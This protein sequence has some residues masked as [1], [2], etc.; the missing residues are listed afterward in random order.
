MTYHENDPEVDSNEDDLIVLWW[1]E[2]LWPEDEWDDPQYS[3]SHPDVETPNGHV[4][5]KLFSGMFIAMLLLGGWAIAG[6]VGFLVAAGLCA[7]T[8]IS[9]RRTTEDVEAT[10]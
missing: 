3:E 1:P 2:D 9:C 5:E 8:L 4:G 7:I 10:A 6:L